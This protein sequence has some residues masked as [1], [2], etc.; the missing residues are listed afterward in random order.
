[1]NTKRMVLLFCCIACFSLPVTGF[2]APATGPKTQPDNSMAFTRLRDLILSSPP[3]K[4]V[5]FARVAELTPHS[6]ATKQGTL[7]SEETYTTGRFAVLETVSGPPVAP[8]IEVDNSDLEA[9]MMFRHGMAV[10]SQMRLGEYWL[11]IYDNK[12]KYVAPIKPGYQQALDGSFRVS[13]PSDPALAA[14]RQFL[15]WMSEPDPQKAFGRARLVLLDAQASLL[16]RIAAYNALKQ[17]LEK[18]NPTAPNQLLHHP[19]WAQTLTELLAQPDLPRALRLE[20]IHSVSIDPAQAVVPGSDAALQFR[21]LLN[22][23]AKI[24]LGNKVDIS[25]LI[26]DDMAEALYFINQ[27][28][29]NHKPSVFYPEILTVLRKRQAM[30]KA[31]NADGS[32]W[33]NRTLMNLDLGGGHYPKDLTPFQGTVRSVPPWPSNALA[34]RLQ[35]LSEQP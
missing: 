35:T 21:Y 33:V 22:G 6:R 18:V 28:S 20:A 32:S 17:S 9:G 27:E 1:M 4:S 30:D 8:Q 15:L 12:I 24:G 29:E 23:V 16:S 31:A 26:V 13:D 2:A 19:L 34:K 3:T 5:L 11:L 10:T 7:S 25:T 14:Y